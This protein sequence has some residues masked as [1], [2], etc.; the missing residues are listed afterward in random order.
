L[1]VEGHSLW[2]GSRGLAS[3]VSASDSVTVLGCVSEGFVSVDAWSVRRSGSR[4]CRAR[5][6]LCGRWESAI[7][8]PV[9][10]SLV[11]ALLAGERSM[12]T[13][14]T[15]VLFRNSGV[16]H[17]LAVSGL[18]V[19]IIA[20]LFLLPGRRGKRLHRRTVLPVVPVLVLYTLLTGARPSTVRAAVMASAVLLLAAGRGERVCYLS[21]W[22]VTALLTAVILPGSIHDRGAQMSFA[23]VLS[24]ILLSPVRGPRSGPV[25]AALAAGLTVTVA[26]APLV[27][28][29]YGGFAPQA[30][31]ATLVSIPFMLATMLLGALVLLPPLAAGA[32]VLVEWCTWAW[33]GVIGLLAMK[34]VTLSGAASACAW[35]GI[36]LVMAFLRW[37]KGF[38]RRFR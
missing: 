19:G 1:E 37:R 22:C 11:C 23:A 18:H 16:S 21:L 5:E 4:V 29:T 28:A 10:C 24:L 6:W 8:S 26:L 13:G 30:P 38:A 34:P 3:A 32:A 27:S 31:V 9:A 12:I 20:G 33:T 7:R 25:A 15:R 36:L 17:M 14:A 35:G 2:A